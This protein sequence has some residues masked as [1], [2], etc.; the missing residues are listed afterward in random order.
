M[1]KPK[2]S[3]ASEQVRMGLGGAVAL[4]IGAMVGGGILAL[5]GVAFSVTGASALL[6][7]IL[8][9][10]IAVIIAMSFAEMASKTPKNGGIYT[11]AKRAL[12]VQLAFG[13]GWVV[14]LASIMA[15]VFYA[16][17]F[18]VFTAF[19][20]QQI[21]V[22]WLQQ[23]AGS[24]IVVVLLSIISVGFYTLKLSR[25]VRVDARRINLIKVAVFAVLI[26]GGIAI[27]PGTPLQDLTLHF[28]PFFTGGIG[29]LAAAMGYTFVAMQ[30]FVLVAYAA[31]DIRN[32]EKNIP[33]ALFYTIGIGMAIYIPLL[34]V[35]LMVGIPE[36]ST[37]AGVS[38]AYPETLIAVAAE[39]YLGKFGLW[40]VL[41]AGTI[42]MLTALQANLFAASRVANSMA[43]DRTLLPQVSRLH[44]RYGTP[45]RAIHLSALLTVIFIMMLPDV[46]SAAAASSLI[47]LLSFALA[48]LVLILMR[49]RSPGKKPTHFQVPFFPALPIAGIAITLSL[50]LFQS[51]VVPSAGVIT[52]IWLFIG[53]LLFIAF[54]L[55]HALVA[56]VSEEA[57]N[58]EIIR[59]RGNSPL[60]LLPIT[61]P[62]NV[63]SKV[64]L[65]QALSPPVVGRTLLLNIVNRSEDAERTAR[66]VEGCRDVIH[67]GLSSALEA[68]LRADTLIT[69]AADPWKEIE[70]VARAHRCQTLLIGPG[71][72]TDEKTT[73]RL[74]QLISR[75]PCDVVVLRQPYTG[76]NISQARKILIPVAGFDKHDLLRARIAA[77]IWRSYQPEITFQQLVPAGVSKKELRTQRRL[78]HRFAEEIIPTGFKTSI[79]Q[80]TDIP[81]TLVHEV[82]QH[83]LVIIGLGRLLPGDKAFGPIPMD[84]IKKT[85]TAA[86]FISHN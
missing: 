6:A 34:L 2:N 8:N 40:L 30:G 60:L 11:Y 55:K 38:R 51:V 85:N 5:A 42:S 21:P 20:L 44:R 77:S 3:S 68:S 32:P 25:E 14:W 66:Q 50:A 65:A 76:W 28:R 74:E 47:F 1:I 53:S 59:L 18:G 84:I 64:F 78:L 15:S 73:R 75:V 82:S 4:G 23:A 79:K 67:Q 54:F 41:I 83:D 9:G 62:A 10:V 69:I 12:S 63:A 19:T 17:G 37:L 58:P 39:H 26:A 81:A 13:V 71:E 43:S 27:I 33:R 24:R 22:D 16:L 45:V 57:R 48:Q 72:F 52:L 35:V 86:I 49:K 70:R 61:N 7:F 31:G 46:A 36:G 29:G 56:D 80:S